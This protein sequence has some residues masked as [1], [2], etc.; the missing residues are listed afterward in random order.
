MINSSLSVLHA[1]CHH[2]IFASITELF[3][4]IVVVLVL[5][6]SCVDHVVVSLLMAST[7]ADGILARRSDSS[8]HE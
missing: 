5:T 7:K 6:D 2:G 1:N 8:I 4:T 3:V